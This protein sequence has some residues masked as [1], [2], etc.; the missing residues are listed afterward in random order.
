[1]SEYFGLLVFCFGLLPAFALLGGIK[2]R[3]TQRE[4]KS[5][6]GAGTWIILIYAGLATAL[7][8]QNPIWGAGAALAIL[9]AWWLG[10]HTTLS[11]TTLGAWQELQRLIRTRVMSVEWS[12]QTS[13]LEAVPIKVDESTPPRS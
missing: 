4:P 8:S 6:L 13:S 11:E 9:A 3:Q 7:L 5:R 1:M 2:Q 12:R 10:R